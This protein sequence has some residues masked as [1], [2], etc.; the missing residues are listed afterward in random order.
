M[1][2][3][4]ARDKQ[5]REEGAKAERERVLD[6]VAQYCQKYAFVDTRRAGKTVSLVPLIRFIQSLRPG[7]KETGK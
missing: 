4:E 3:A 2:N 6:D 5:M 1:Q 7:Q